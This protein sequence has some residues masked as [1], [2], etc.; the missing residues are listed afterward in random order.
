MGSCWNTREPYGPVAAMTERMG[1]V[2]DSRT[3][4][5]DAELV[6]QSASDPSAFELVFARHVTAI[7]RFVARRVEPA[8]VEELVSETFATAFDRR[9]RYR[10]EYPD[11]RPWLF[12][13]A[14]N[15]MRHHRRSE[16]ARLAAY[17]RVDP[18]EPVD[19][20]DGEALERLDARAGRGEL[21]R[22]LGKL[23]RGDRDALLLLAWGELSYE[24]IALALDIPV[25]T[26]RSRINR[27][28]RRLRELLSGLEAIDEQNHPPVLDDTAVS[29]R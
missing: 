28:R 17:A 11:A 18:A 14:T 19:G 22:A 27:A 26:V 10:R 29:Y 16:R 2:R 25:G 7:H 8:V 12:G 13:I 20:V 5:S 15:L 1:A 21:A 4:C 6:L 24:E 23:R 3:L 9:G